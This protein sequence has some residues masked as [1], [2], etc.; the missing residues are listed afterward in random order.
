MTQS[1]KWKKFLRRLMTEF[2][3]RKYSIYYGNENGMELH[4]GIP[5]PEILIERYLSYRCTMITAEHDGYRLITQLWVHDRVYLLVL[6]SDEYFS[7]TDICYILND[8]AALQ[9]ELQAYG[10]EYQ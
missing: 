8:V 9:K 5:V 4:L 2:S 1:D 6:Y 10:K 7:D 3:V